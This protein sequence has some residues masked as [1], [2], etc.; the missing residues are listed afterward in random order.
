LGT[1]TI[2]DFDGLP[3]DVEKPNP[4]GR[5]AA[6][7]S[8]AVALATEDKAALGANTDG[9]WVGTGNASLV[10]VLKA[11]FLEAI[12]DASVSI[13][14]PPQSIT[15]CV[16]A[17][18]DSLSAGVDLGLLRLSAIQLPANI[19]GA[20]TLSFQGSIDGVTWANVYT[21]AGTEKT[22]T[23]ALSRFVIVDWN[24]FRGLRHLK[25]RL[26]TAGAPITTTAERTLQLL[27]ES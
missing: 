15:P 4:H 19:D 16:I 18:A 7:A 14:A 24:D 2:A 17:S 8:V 23:V 6:A 13:A 25:V 27:A 1:I 12:D 10:A 21:A 9:P 20:A 11:L 5:A 22:V 3:V 26:G